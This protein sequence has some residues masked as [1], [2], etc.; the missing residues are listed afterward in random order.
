MKKHT[1]GRWFV[2]GLSVLGGKGPTFR[3]ICVVSDDRKSGDEPVANSNLICA[4]PELLKAAK[5]AEQFINR[6]QSDWSVLTDDQHGEYPG[7]KSLEALKKA[8]ATAEG[9]S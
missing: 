6:F 4:A 2:A 1:S 5:L 9:I 7:L 3:Q 8:I